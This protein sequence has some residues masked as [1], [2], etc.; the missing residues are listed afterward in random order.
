MGT[1]TKRGPLTVKQ[2]TDFLSKIPNDYDVII[3]NQVHETDYSALESVE[4]GF[5]VDDNKKVVIMY[6]EKQYFYHE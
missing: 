5:I 1:L 2:V 6:F 4:E 3:L